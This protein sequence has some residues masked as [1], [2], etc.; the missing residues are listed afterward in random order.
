L[1]RSLQ[2]LINLS[3]FA[4]PRLVWNE[5]EVVGRRAEMVKNEGDWDNVLHWS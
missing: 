1:Q 5:S 3:H 2:Y 4:K